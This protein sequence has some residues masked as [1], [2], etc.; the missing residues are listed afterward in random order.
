MSQKVSHLLGRRIAQGAILLFCSSLG[1][2]QVNVGHSIFKGNRPA[3]NIP[4]FILELQRS[5][6]SHFDAGTSYNQSNSLK[7]L[8]GKYWSNDEAG[9]ADSTLTTPNETAADSSRPTKS[10]TLAMLM[11][12]VIP[13]AGQVY[14]HRY[15]TIPIIWGF[16][17]YLAKAWNDQNNRYIYYRDLFDASVKADTVNHQGNGV[18]QSNRDFYRDDRDKFAFY[19]AIT[20]VLNIVDAYVGASL[21]SFDVSD[22][23]GGSAAIRLR[24]PIQ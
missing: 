14:V 19:L 3:E 20:Y 24:I 11:S 9:S 13:G 7:P 21:Y 1:L 15:F 18:Y 16:G 4:P 2:A 10:P 5:N 23:L 12:V 17:Y 6:G 22:N 8:G